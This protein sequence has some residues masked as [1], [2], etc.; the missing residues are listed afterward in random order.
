MHRAIGLLRYAGYDQKAGLLNGDWGLSNR[1]PRLM[2][3]LGRYEVL[4]E[5][6]AG[7]AVS[8]SRAKLADGRAANFA[9]KW[10][11]LRNIEPEELRKQSD[12]FLERARI[13]QRVGASP[14]TRRWA[15]IRYLGKL[16]T[17]A[18]YVTDYFPASADNWIADP[19]PVSAPALGLLVSS[20]VEGLRELRGA[21]DR[22]HGSLKPSNVLIGRSKSG[23]TNIV[24]T[25]PGTASEAQRVGESGDLHALGELIHLLV[26][27]R[28]PAPEDQGSIAPDEGWDRLGRNGEAWRQLCSDL[29]TPQPE[30]TE[31]HLEELAAVVEGFKKRN[32]RSPG[33]WVVRAAIAATLLVVTATVLDYAAQRGFCRSRAEWLDA[34]A[35]AVADPQRAQ[36]Y[37]R[38]SALRQ[39]MQDTA[40]AE[41]GSPPSGSG[42][43]DLR[44]WN[45]PELRA[46]LAAM[47]RVRDDLSPAQWSVAAG[48][49]A[50]QH[51][52]E[53]HGW[54]QPAS[55]VSGKL[56]QVTSHPGP[57]LA[58][59]VD[60]LPIFAAAIDA[61]RPELEK[62]WGDL[63]SASRQLES[64]GDAYLATFGRL[65]RRSAADALRL[66]DSGFEGV[67]S[68]ADDGVMAAQMVAAL[69]AGYPK[70][71]DAQRFFDDVTSRMN[72]AKLGM[73]DVR[74]WID[75]EPLY[76]HQDNQTGFV[77]AEL[78]RNLR[79]NLQK[80]AAANPPA[81]DLVSAEGERQSIQRLLDALAQ[82]HFIVK[83]F[84]DGT[85]AAQRGQIDA[86]ISALLVHV[87][88]DDPKP[89]L[90]SLPTLATHSDVINAYWEDWK[91]VLETNAAEM[92]RRGDV[93]HKFK[94][95]TERLQTALTAL[96][97][98]FPLPPTDLSAPFATAAKQQRES[99]L[100][101]LLADMDP[102]DPSP[103]LPNKKNLMDYYRQWCTNLTI[104]GKQF[105]L[106]SELLTLSDEPDQAWRSKQPKF[107]NDPMVRGLVAKDVDRLKRLRALRDLAR[108]DLIDA[109]TESTIPE[110]SFAAWQLL[111]GSN[112][113]PAWPTQNGEL[114]T[115]ADLRGKLA[116]MIAAIKDPATRSAPLAAL[117][118]QRVV[119]WRRFVEAARNDV[120][121]EQA[122]RLQPAF[123]NEAEL[124][125]ALS[126]AAQFDVALYRCRQLTDRADEKTTAAMVAELEHA[127]HLL[128]PAAGLQPLLDR[129]SRLAMKE[130]F[131]DHNPGD[132]FELN[133]PGLPQPFIFQRVEPEGARPFYL[134]TT[135]VSFGQ[136]AGVIGSLNA[137]DQA[138][139]FPWGADPNKRDTRRGPR[140]WEWVQ[141]PSLQMV[142][143]LLWFFPEDDNDFAPIFRI[144]R[145]N[146][147]AVSDDVGGNPSPDHP[148]QQIP[149]EAAFY[150]A[151][152]CGCRL[153]TADEWRS[154]Y[155]IFERTVPAERWNL[156]DQ[157]WNDQL[158]Y[159]AA[160]TG[161][162]VRWPDEGIFI[163]D[164]ITVPT[165]SAAKARDENDGTLFFR[166][167]G[168][169]G[170]GTF[171]QL[172]GNVAQFLCD[173]PEA[174]DAWQDKT[175]PT[176]IRRFIDEH[177]NSLYVIGGSALSPP[178]VPLQ[179]P[180]PV[181]HSDVGYSDVGL[182]LAFTAP[183]HSPAER[184]KWALPNQSYFWPK[185]PTTEPT[186]AATAAGR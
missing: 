160:S 167:V 39:A 90:K 37:Q 127:A 130:P 49:L 33:K 139:A 173:A 174:F 185:P 157:T 75:R 165:G 12:A 158:Q 21:A 48:L 162:N 4:N 31:G 141:R 169:A 99:E 59:T 140:V 156:R 52:F 148:M 17:G 60:Q 93:F 120:M 78:E 142:T 135:A 153:P 149:A 163:P 112:V 159:A 114:E 18:F 101:R 170:G 69:K 71:I 110:I 123:G 89:W 133:L 94:Q 32:K 2:P 121:L 95:Q 180:L 64:S 47:H 45:F 100:G 87:R 20:V 3:I 168:A 117:G 116:T 136:F 97:S 68:V 155:A 36:R 82:T 166:K 80:V 85:F 176:G 115:E 56:A 50:A 146:R 13:Q 145:F 86:R 43:F 1:P 51:D 46:R 132:R 83:D 15:P 53:A 96:D 5:L 84:N 14:N 178:D 38:D 147:T 164:G 22:A 151:G 138:A 102:S 143:P 41:R 122:I 171:H 25:D 111:G 72:L 129:L 35:T 92:G 154:A 182:R 91:H 76:V 9:V 152:L 134:C 65:L 19:A 16:P 23:D 42:L 126:P 144:D 88:M 6:H 137:W 54:T 62:R 26:T 103:L 106:R 27:R 186:A 181:T 150:Y 183:A 63:D 172:I 67:A 125:A 161:P 179:T 28:L 44:P 8:V 98:D 61:Q 79:Q 7:S 57:D 73:L 24:L 184:L 58:K 55:F 81:A 11:Q 77:V 107:W 104:L 124:V 118:Q 109:A 175:T 40:E 74:H 105:P 113:Y 131:A 177:P 30:P 10:L 34:F 119:R 66:G 128:P 29:L 70:N 108:S